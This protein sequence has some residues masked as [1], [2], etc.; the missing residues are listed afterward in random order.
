[1]PNRHP[2]L[3]KGAD[4]LLTGSGLISWYGGPTDPDDNGI[5]AWGFNSKER[6]Y[7]PY[8]ALPRVYVTM[9][10]LRQ[11]QQVTVEFKGRQVVCVLTDIGPGGTVEADKRL[12]DVG[13]YVMKRLD[14]DTDDTV[15]IFIP[16]GK[17]LPAE[18]WY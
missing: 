18:K 16:V 9:Y 8:C 5:G 10:Q 4:G 11:G 2:K 3:T 13:P 7:A 12:I 17:I 6:P 15:K 14:C 1:M